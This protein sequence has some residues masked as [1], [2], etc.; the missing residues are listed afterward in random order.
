MSLKNSA[1]NV[2]EALETVLMD[3]KLKGKN[4]GIEGKH[5]HSY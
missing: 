5:K 3:V 4:I 1:R 2:M